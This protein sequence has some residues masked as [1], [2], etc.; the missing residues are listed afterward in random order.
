MIVHQIETVAF[1]NLRDQ[2]IT[3]GPRFNVLSGANAQGK[4]NFLDALYVVACLRSFRA[5]RIAEIIRFHSSEGRIAAQVVCRG[6]RRELEVQLHQGGRR[7][8]LD[9]KGVRGSAS[10]LEAGLSVVLFA[11][12]DVQLPRG[13][14]ADRRRLVDRAIANLWPGYIDLA[15]DYQKTLQS[16]NRVLRESG[17]RS[18]KGLLEVYSQQLAELAARVMATRLRYLRNLSPSVTKI[19]A[20]ITRSG[21]RG[22][23]Q[24][25][26]PAALLELGDTDLGALAAGLRR[27]LQAQLAVDRARQTTTVGPHT[28]DVGFVLDGRSTRSYGSQGQLR[29]LV[30]SFKIAQVVDAKAKRDEVPVLLLDDV[31]SE[32]DADCNTYLFDF[33][34]KID[35][36]AFLTTTRPELVPIHDER[37]DFQVVKGQISPVV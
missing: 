4:T 27:E 13:S 15:R 7:A 26:A 32:L 18:A 36:Q 37:L 21:A 11:P 16:R 34:Y 2:T 31:S 33:L 20:E 22:H 28:H 3:P 6:L 17:A 30:L 35:C 10:Y 29:S 24:Y 9:G 14:P 12:D 1:R 5:R 19:F 25:E 8:K 23:L